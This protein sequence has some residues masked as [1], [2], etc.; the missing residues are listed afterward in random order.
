MKK[1]LISSGA[2][3]EKKVGYSRA[4][5]YG[6]VIEVSGTTSVNDGQPFLP[7]DYYGQTL[8]IYEIISQALQ[9][10]GASLDDIVRIRVFVVDITQ[11]ESV[12]KAHATLFSEIRPAMTMVGVQGLID[13]RLVVEIEATAII[14]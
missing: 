9:Q 1:Q 10:G 14:Q 8:R 5:K 11:W 3:W 2:I 12:A 13:P 4:V 6:N 7:Y